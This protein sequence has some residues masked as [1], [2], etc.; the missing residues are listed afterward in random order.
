MGSHVQ[1]SNLKFGMITQDITGKTYN[2]IHAAPYT[3]KD[4]VSQ[5][6]TAVWLSPTD[7]FG[8][9]RIVVVP[10]EFSY[11]IIIPE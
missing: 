4:T 7:G 11:W 5:D 2:V 10:N 6:R 8:K 1:A 9:D 3:Y